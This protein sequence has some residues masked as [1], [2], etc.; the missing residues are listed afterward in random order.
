MSR[1]IS[2]F[3]GPTHPELAKQICQYIDVPLGKVRV[4]NFANGNTFVKFDEVVRDRDVFIVQ[5]GA[6]RPGASV[7][8]SLME[9]FIMTDA[10]RRASA[11]RV[12]AV[13][14]FY[15]YGRTDKKDQSRVPVTARLMADLLVASGINRV[16]TIDLHA[17]QIQGFFPSSVPLDE[18]TAF[19]LL[20]NYVAGLRLDNLVVVATDLG[21][22]KRA[23][24]FARALDCP[25]AF[26]NKQRH[27]N[28]D[29]ATA[30][31]LIGAD[32]VDGRKVLLVDDEVD[33]AGS[34]T[35]AIRICYEHGATEIYA[36]VTHGVFSGPAFERIE[37]SIRDH[38]LR[39]LIVTDTLPQTDKGYAHDNIR[40]LSVAELLA[41][42]IRRIHYG[43]SVGDIYRALYGDRIAVSVG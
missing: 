3:S 4:F 20:C 9:L 8:D 5:P 21:I 18:V 2:I 19:Y 40:V 14:P 25:I 36:A 31:N 22:A 35:E 29:R 32:I 43:E 30:E 39:E 1:E 7:N 24:N 10:A 6:S 16:L 27:G 11:W 33:T 38:G 41:E 28:S 12:T 13:I 37:N 17:G 23:S 26:V 15:A 42:T 34:L